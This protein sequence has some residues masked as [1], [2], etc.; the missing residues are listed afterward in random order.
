MYYRIS[1]I[2]HFEGLSYRT[3]KEARSITAREYPDKDQHFQ[4]FKM[5]F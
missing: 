1:Y 3:W 4:N 5:K 2:G